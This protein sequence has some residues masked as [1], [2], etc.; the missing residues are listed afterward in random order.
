[1]EKKQGVSGLKLISFAVLAYFFVLTGHYTA[2]LLL[3]GF[4]ILIEK[5][6]WLN[7][8]I[9]QVLL[10]RVI[11]DAT[12]SLWGFIYNF[13]HRDFLDLFE[14]KHETYRTLSD[15]NDGFLNVLHYAFMILLIIGFI[16]LVKSKNPKIPLINGL[17]KKAL[18]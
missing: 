17:V 13:I 14:T 9:G 12:T 6:E 5:D 8:Q 3:A 11:Y 7:L 15:F 16:N 2:L 4:A 1:M 10:L 18:K